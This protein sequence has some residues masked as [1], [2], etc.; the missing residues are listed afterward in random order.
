[1]SVTCKVICPL[2]TQ[3]DRTHYAIQILTL[4]EIHTYVYCYPYLTES[5]VLPETDQRAKPLA[6]NAS[7]EYVFIKTVKHSNNIQ[8]T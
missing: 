6:C 2:P 3:L 4:F 8:L 7:W 1:M 5:M